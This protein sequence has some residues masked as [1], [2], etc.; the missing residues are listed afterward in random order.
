MNQKIFK[1]RIWFTAAAII[2]LSFYAAIRL[3]SLHFSDKIIA[4]PAEK[5]EARRG[6]I[7]DRNGYILA[8]T[9]D[10]WSVY[11]N[12]EEIKHASDT[13]ARLSAA[14]GLSRSHLAERMERKRRFVWL[15]RKIDAASMEEIKK[16]KLDGI[17]FRKEYL[18]VYPH[19]SLASNIIGFTGV[20]NAGLEGIE[21]QY[22][23]LLKSGYDSD[24]EIV[25]GRNIVLTIDSYIQKKAED[26]LKA[27]VDAAGAKQGAAIVLDIK[28]AQILALAKYP[29]YNP[30]RYYAYPEANLRN[31]SVID[32]YEPGSTMKIFSMAAAYEY[33]QELF[34]KAHECKGSIEIAGVVINC[35]R[36]HGHVTVK[37]IISQSCNVGVIETMRTLPRKNFYDFLKRFGFGKKTEAGFPGETEGILR[38]VDQ[39]SGLSKYSMAIGYEFSLTSLQLAAAYSAIANNGLYNVPLIVKRIEDQDGGII[40]EFSAKNMGSVC[41]PKT[42]AVMLQLMRGVITDGTG[43]RAA[44]EYYHVA[45]KT[46]TSKKF[47]QT[48]GLYTDSQVS[49]FAGIVPLEDP[50]LCVL[51][52]IDAPS[53]GQGGGSA[54][55]PVFAGIAGSA[56]P[57]L[58]VSA[59]T[60][61]AA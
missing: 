34:K 61:K 29:G 30:N 5:K 19:D 58:R 22:N 48:K 26:Q 12:P 24:D 28:S 35:E 32:S 10:S 25:Y 27:A 57:Y 53:S 52:I 31:F 54:A 11:A 40:R 44:L 4:E 7:K 33:N 43:K 50:S 1:R 14:I 18:R 9:I 17:H 21:Y 2:L 23:T 45:G 3:F 16:L 60:V 46:G 13:A 47:S 51:V 55:A 39:W 37:E 59:N 6:S 42:A 15:K 8:M 49:S 20:D 56:L 36:P 41:S 38:S